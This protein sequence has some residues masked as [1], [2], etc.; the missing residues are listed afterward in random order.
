MLD[1]DGCGKC[2]GDVKGTG[3]FDFSIGYFLCKNCGGKVRASEETYE[4]LRLAAGL[5]ADEEKAKNGRCRA[6]RLIKAYLTKKTDSEYPCLSEF[7]KLYQGEKN[8]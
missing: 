8:D 7:I 5:E 1:L 6:L 2:H 3:F 4:A